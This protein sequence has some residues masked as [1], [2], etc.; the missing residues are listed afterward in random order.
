MSRGHLVYRL[1]L[2]AYPAS[3]RAERGEEILSTLL[4]ARGEGTL[5]E[6]REVAALVAGGLRQRAAISP[7]GRARSWR[8]GA[9]LAAYVLATVN[10]AVALL[11]VIQEQRLRWSVDFGVP[12]FGP[13]LDVL[14]LVITPWFAAFAVTALATLVLLAIGAR[15]AAAA[16]ALAGFAVQAF[17]LLRTP[18]TAVPGGHFAVYA[19]TNSSSLPREPSQWLPAS[20]LLAGLIVVAGAPTRR[21]VRARVALAVA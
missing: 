11:G 18:H 13:R 14:G 12:G 20:L 17:E 15:R 6:P 21:P 1:A 3:Y 5:P 19:W 2:H 16:C 10:A 4:D 8:S 9:L 7:G